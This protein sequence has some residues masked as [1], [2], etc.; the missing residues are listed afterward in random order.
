MMMNNAWQVRQSMIQ[1]SRKPEPERQVELYINE[2]MYLSGGEMDML[3]I[4]Y[5]LAG[6][7]EIEIMF[8]SE[9]LQNAAFEISKLPHPF[10]IKNIQLRSLKNEII[11]ELE[12][13]YGESWITQ[14]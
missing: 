11:K 8:S 12:L 9:Q 5:A 6:Y 1:S 7:S 4:F 3:C 14:T 10:Q 2:N 13:N